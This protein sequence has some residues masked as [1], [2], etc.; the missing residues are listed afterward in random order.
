MAEGI[1]APAPPDFD[2]ILI[3]DAD[4]FIERRRRLD[5]TTED[6]PRVPRIIR[7]Q[8]S[9]VEHRIIRVP[10]IHQFDRRADRIDGFTHFIPGVRRSPWR[11]VASQPSAYLEFETQMVIIGD[12]NFR[13]AI[14]HASAEN[15]A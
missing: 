15:G 5:E 14:H 13:A 9:A 8:R 3:G 11:E 6:D 2:T 4:D 7:D 10:I 12:P 1:R